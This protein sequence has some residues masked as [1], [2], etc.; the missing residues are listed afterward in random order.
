MTK[1][2]YNSS[3]RKSTFFSKLKKDKIDIITWI[4]DR[5]HKP[6]Q[7]IEKE[8]GVS[9]NTLKEW[10]KQKQV[11]IKRRKTPLKKEIFESFMQKEYTCE[12]MAREISTTKYSSINFR[13][14]E[15]GNLIPLRPIEVLKK[16][17]EFNLVGQDE[18]LSKAYKRIKEPVPNS[19]EIT[20]KEVFNFFSKYY[21]KLLDKEARHLKELEQKNMTRTYRQKL[22]IREQH[23][24]T[25]KNIM[26]SSGL[27]E[28][29]VLEW[30]IK[31]LRSQYE[32]RCT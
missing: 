4:K 29:P 5:E 17:R 23:I 6:R 10:A 8:A 30:K 7:E 27:L 24:I 18:D 21:K 28:V 3:S 13:T 11:D 31:Q 15:D 9:W 2:L 1:K 12:Q 20:R 19:Y 25:M 32:K 16:L 22:K 26:E 14:D